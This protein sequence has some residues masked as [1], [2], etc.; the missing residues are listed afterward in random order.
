M[1][2]MINATEA[3][4]HFS[5]VMQRA[6]TAPVIITWHGKPEVVVISKDEY[7]RL[8]EAA[9]KSD[10][11]KMLEET[12]ELIRKELNGRQLP[13]PAE[14]IR[15]GREERDVQLFMVQGEEHL[16]QLASKHG[17]NWDKLSEDEREQFIDNLL[18]ERP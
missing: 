2:D 14:M 7:D 3:R 5:E 1:K 15:R 10:W 13:D 4:T 17:L 11:R 6:Q 8:M 18:H 9:P 16:Q 12:H